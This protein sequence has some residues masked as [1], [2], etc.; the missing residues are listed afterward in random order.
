MLLG[1]KKPPFEGIFPLEPPRQPIDFI[2]T[3]QRL[4]IWVEQVVVHNRY[5]YLKRKTYY[6][7]SRV[8]KAKQQ[9]ITDYVANN[10]SHGCIPQPAFIDFDLAKHVDWIKYEA[11]EQYRNENIR[12]WGLM[13][14]VNHGLVLAEKQ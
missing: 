6:F 12:Q 1:I 8:P 2:R 13:N 5:I 4:K 7:V 9:R 10:P 3:S 14:C 11:F